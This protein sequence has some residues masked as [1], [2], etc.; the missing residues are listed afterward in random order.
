MCLKGERSLNQPGMGAGSVTSVP[1]RQQVLLLSKETIRGGL[2]AF[3]ASIIA[4]T[5]TGYRQFCV[6]QQIEEVIQLL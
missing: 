2:S 5:R 1:Y 6:L 3:L 4:V